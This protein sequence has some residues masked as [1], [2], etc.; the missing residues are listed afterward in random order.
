MKA[1]Y[2]ERKNIK[3][4]AK[5]CDNYFS[6]Y[7]IQKS[8]G[9]WRGKTEPSI[10]IT[11]T[12]RAGRDIANLATTINAHNGQDCCLVTGAGDYKILYRIFTEHEKIK[13]VK[14][15]ISRYFEG[16][17]LIK[18]T[19]QAVFEIIADRYVKGFR[20]GTYK[21]DGTGCYIANDKSPADIRTI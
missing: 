20:A 10:K 7:E 9:V 11:G 14:R 3:A 16:Y 17:T 2:T 1:L 21:K 6:S 18:E 13:A 5:W 15:V 12:E 4:V 19:G 8:I